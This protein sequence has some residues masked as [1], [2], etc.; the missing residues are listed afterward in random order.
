MAADGRMLLRE[1]KSWRRIRIFTT[2]L[3]PMVI[4]SVPPAA[5][6]SPW[7]AFYLGVV[8]EERMSP[9]EEFHEAPHKRPGS[10]SHGVAAGQLY[11]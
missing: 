10:R 5:S 3:W 1:R 2:T 7:P 4:T 11:F 6:W 9:D 8:D